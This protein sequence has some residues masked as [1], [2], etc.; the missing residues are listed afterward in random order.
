MLLSFPAWQDSDD[1][2]TLYR[3]GILPD[4]YTPQRKAFLFILVLLHACPFLKMNKPILE[5]KLTRTSGLVYWV[6]SV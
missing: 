1:R 6:L 2:T 4:S 5:T 3:R